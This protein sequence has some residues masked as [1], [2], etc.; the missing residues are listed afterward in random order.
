MIFILLLIIIITIIK[1]M[2]EI[3]HY[4][5]QLH[6]LTLEASAAHFPLA[7]VFA[8]SSRSINFV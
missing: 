4:F 6:V 3:N 2:A 5:G 8:I 7:T 1:Q